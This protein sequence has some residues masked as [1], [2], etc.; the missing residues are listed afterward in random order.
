MS[1]APRRVR[2][3]K[4]AAAPAS[5]RTSSRSRAP[6]RASAATAAYGAAPSAAA[7][8][9]RRRP[10]RATGAE[11][12]PSPSI[13]SGQGSAPVV[14]RAAARP[15]SARRDRRSSSAM[16]E[17]AVKPEPAPAAGPP[18]AASRRSEH[19]Q[20]SRRPARAPAAQPAAHRRETSSHSS[21]ADDGYGD[22]SFEDYEDEFEDDPD[23]AA[24]AA[25]AAYSARPVPQ[26]AIP[27]GAHAFDHA[28]AMDEAVFADQE[29]R[30]R[31]LVAVVA[32]PA[33]AGP[34]S[35]GDGGP[36]VSLGRDDPARARIAGLHR[37]GVRLESESATVV[38]RRK[39]TPEDRH[40]ERLLRGLV[41]QR[42]LQTGDPVSASCQ[43]EAA[44]T[45]EQAAQFPED[46]A[47][48]AALRAKARRLKDEDGGGSGSGSGSGSGGQ[49][50]TPSAE[51]EPGA[52]SGAGG[53]GGRGTS[54]ARLL[55]DESERL[56]AFLARVVGTMEAVL[57]EAAEEQAGWGAAARG[58]AGPL[59]ELVAPSS[60]GAAAGGGG[61]RGGAR[62]PARAVVVSMTEGARLLRG[63]AAVAA[64]FAP[65]NSHA[66]VA[67]GPAPEAWLDG[68]EAAVAAAM[69]RA[70]PKLLAL[71]TSAAMRR[72]DA[73]RDGAIAVFSAHDMRSG[74]PAAV[75]ACPGEITAVSASRPR[76]SVVV[77]GTAHGSVVVWDTRR[78]DASQAPPGCPLVALGAA[79]GLP[80]PLRLP[81]ATTDV[82]VDPFVAPESSWGRSDAAIVERAMRGAGAGGAARDA[83][84]AALGTHAR[85]PGHRAP[86]VEIACAGRDSAGASASA[87]APA[88][89]TGSTVQVTSLDATG[90]LIAWTLVAAEGGGLRLV[91]STATDTC[92]ALPRPLQLYSDFAGLSGG[93]FPLI[94]PDGAPMGNK[95]SLG[96]VALA[97]ST[98]LSM[99]EVGE[100]VTAVCFAE[101]D[102]VLVGTVDG[103]VARASR[104]GQQGDAAAGSSL[105]QP[106]SNALSGAA[107]LQR[108]TSLGGATPD[109]ESKAAIA[110][111]LF[112]NVPSAVT[113]LAASPFVPGAAVVGYADGSL[114]LFGAGS[115]YP[116]RAWGDAAPA[117]HAVCSAVWSP[118]RAAV[119]FTLDTAGVLRG[120]DLAALPSRPAAAASV[121]REAGIKG[122]GGSGV[123]GL[124]KA[125]GADDGSSGLPRGHARA[126]PCLRVNGAAGSPAARP[127][128]LATLPDGRGAVVVPLARR[129]WDPASAAV[130]P[131]AEAHAAGAAETR[132]AGDM[133]ASAPGLA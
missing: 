93:G 26:R 74:A 65:T 109:E 36:T 114:R 49:A 119:F 70:D 19:N 50:S 96:D 23:Q 79:T 71:A 39:V 47:F 82:T 17:D 104:F 120:W 132:W 108:P 88:S 52:Q 85:F 111:R 5:G 76:G 133:F 34:G 94:G 106:T 90:V 14:T 35:G 10:V 31:P 113:A 21:A 8:A 124:F 46:L 97:S 101:D 64:A 130:D 44:D 95:A 6:V 41:R 100:R 59:A 78:R 24:A 123:A 103:A 55:A 72:L 116:L 38:S 12:G 4:Q 66:V 11:R 42:G 122:K 53:A 29:R 75:L 81:D 48:A 56:S 28:A 73:A 117:G 86:V 18:A 25:A 51:D 16:F 22:D 92:S 1:G 62:A 131:S 77:A 84:Q 37:R 115:S 98:P 80:C 83:A 126:R 40:T 33:A 27:G 2:R 69:G 107:W 102:E 67:F 110:P 43:T 68:A 112:P 15:A 32:S 3:V 9:A 87:A 91:W 54:V 20:A 7:P 125:A 99:W 128:L 45:A 89:S 30:R 105:K 63:R 58:T 121:L 60:E 57:D 127:S 13:P 118:T 61:R 129:W